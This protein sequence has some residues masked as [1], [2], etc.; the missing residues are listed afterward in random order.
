MTPLR[1]MAALSRRESCR[2]VTQCNEFT[3]LRVEKETSTLTIQ[4]QQPH[5][6]SSV[7]S[8]LSYYVLL[9]EQ[10]LYDKKKYD[11]NRIENWTLLYLKSPMSKDSAIHSHLA[12]DVSRV[13]QINLNPDMLKAF[14]TLS[15]VCGD[16]SESVRQNLQNTLG[17]RI[18]SVN[19]EICDNF[20]ALKARYD[21]AM[22]LLNE[23]EK[24]CSTMSNHLRDTRTETVKLINQIAKLRK[25]IEYTENSTSI[26]NNFLSEFQ[27][28]AE[29]LDALKSSTNEN[30]SPNFF[31]A[32]KRAE[33]I[34]AAAKQLSLSGTNTVGLSIVENMAEVM[35]SAFDTLYHFI[36]T[37]CRRMTSE[38]VSIGL[39]LCEAFM[40][41]QKRC[42]IFEYS[43][44]EFC[45]AR[46][47][48]LIHIFID[49]LSKSSDSRIKPIESYSHDPLHYIGDMLALIHQATVNEKE[50]LL[51]L[52]KLCDK[53]VLEKYI[54]L[55]LSKITDG[56]SR[57]FKIRAEQTLARPLGP[58]IL[59]QLYVMFHFHL[60]TVGE[61]LSKQ[62]ELRSC[63]D[64][65]EQLAMKLFQNCLNTKVCSILKK[66]HAC[67]SDL[68]PVQGVS[69]LLQLLRDVLHTPSG[70]T[71]LHADDKKRCYS[72]VFAS[73][74]DPMLQTLTMY[75]TDLSPVDFATYMLNCINAVH[76]AVAMYEFSN[77]RL[78]MLQAQIEVHLGNVVNEMANYIL[79]KVGLTEA[80]KKALDNN[81]SDNQRQSFQLPS[82]DFNSSLEKFYTFLNSPE[83]LFMPQFFKISSPTI[84]NK[85]KGKTIDAL[86]GVYD[87]IQNS[88]HVARHLSEIKA[89]AALATNQK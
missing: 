31:H 45:S 52:L 89:L 3:F 16:K 14:K 84:Q 58:V 27:L 86:I 51:S 24:S 54:P 30:L 13:L 73:V 78:E 70:T 87:K 38:T 17:N 37:Q 47:S 69:E 56:L 76:S 81:N 26:L 28:K 18:L 4:T 83:T 82:P 65:C 41:M 9:D 32:I 25:Q 74:I 22:D 50:L 42:T 57:P 5:N 43:L 48:F 2:Q 7:V 53:G 88:F 10:D 72:L 77:Q 75:S 23:M 66:F 44:E 36:Q 59:Y 40:T 21:D 1:R 63:L 71:V 35:R 46:R 15:L 60:T 61:K 6:S 11:R 62:S 67:Q 49:S 34:H 20:S 68:V 79:N 33:Q 80:Y 64:D 55:A 12:M 85:V 8:C 19:K 39:T 29:E